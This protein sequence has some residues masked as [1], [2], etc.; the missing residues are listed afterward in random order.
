MPTL[1]DLPAS[2][3]DPS[4]IEGD[5]ARDAAGGPHGIPGKPA[6]PSPGLTGRARGC[7]RA[8]RVRPV[9]LLAAIAVAS[10]VGLQLLTPLHLSAPPISAGLGMWILALACVSAVLFARTFVYTRRLRD[11]LVVVAV[12][13]LSLIDLAFRVVPSMAGAR[14]AVT[15]SGL[16]VV[17]ILIGALAMAAA[18]FAPDDTVD[19]R[20][21]LRVVRIVAIVAGAAVCVGVLVAAVWAGAEVSTAGGASRLHDTLAA[22][23]RISVVLAGCG[24]LILAAVG[25]AR[26][27]HQ[28][29]ERHAYWLAVASALFAAACATSLSL[30]A[31]TADRIVPSDGL[32]LFAFAALLTAASIRRMRV[33]DEAA[34]A[35]IASEHERLARDLHDGLA[36]DLAVIAIHAQRRD[37][38]GEEARALMLAA[39]RALAASRMTILDLSASA[40]PT[41]EE[42]MRQITDELSAL[43]DVAVAVRVDS[44]VQQLTLDAQGRQDLIRIA[45][46]AITNAA[47]HGSARCIDVV[48][49]RRNDALRLS[50]LDDGCGIDDSELQPAHGFGM[51]MMRAR[52]QTLGGWLTTRRSP[53]GGTELELLIPWKAWT[54]RGR[55]TGRKTSPSHGTS[56]PLGRS[57]LTAV[58]PRRTAP[59]EEVPDRAPHG[60]A[61]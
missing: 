47:R 5:P 54:P 35:A 58:R 28:A 31:V 44:G 25:F 55:K 4:W 51:Q 33:C 16:Y 57:T 36:Q 56:H 2:V 29:Q 60:G 61:S 14:G 59:H 22:V 17:A 18:A 26:R 23:L 13:W 32:R 21:I 52:A 1:A 12:T 50:V 3:P 6:T 9:T 53:D 41:I 34:L 27:E 49:D 42:A 30:G 46:E 7:A 8:R 43:Y 45:R 20:W 48:L 38:G 40:A 15:A 11:L 19:R 39:R 10:G 24:A 37:A